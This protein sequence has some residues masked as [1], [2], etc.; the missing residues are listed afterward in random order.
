MAFNGKILLVFFFCPVFYL[1][2]DAQKTE[3]SFPPS[4]DSV[5]VQK[6]SIYSDNKN[7]ISSDSTEN[8]QKKR[9]RRATLYSAILPGAG[10]VYNKKYWKV[11]L[12]YSSLAIPV[13]FYFSNK[14]IYQEAQYALVV[15][16]NRSPPDSLDK[17]QP[18]LRPF[19][20]A[21]DVNGLITGRD[22]AR[23][24]QDY[25]ALFFIL[26]YA[27]NIVDATV[28]AHLKGFNVSS[29]LSFEVKPAILPGEPLSPGMTIAFNVHKSKTDYTPH[30]P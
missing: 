15:T 3:P 16:I 9:Y 27:L 23:K 6:D 7:T 1:K 28:D 20:K 12:V 30:L 22:E 18:Y 2:T 5:L 4:S 29:N 8:E 25:S 17:V 11:P 21:G 26:F 10:Q 14:T 19:V 13:Y 24:N